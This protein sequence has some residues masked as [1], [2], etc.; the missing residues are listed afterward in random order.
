[1]PPLPPP[2]LLLLLLLLLLLAEYP[3][4][5]QGAALLLHWPSLSC[6][7]ALAAGS[8]E[9]HAGDKRAWWMLGPCPTF[10]MFEDADR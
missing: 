3:L 8:N 7:R 10:V 6:S 1:V 5:V 9:A 2:P 4:L